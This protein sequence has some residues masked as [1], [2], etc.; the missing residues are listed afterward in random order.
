MR[1]R[2]KNSSK[3]HNAAAYSVLVLLLLVVAVIGYFVWQKQ[4]GRIHTDDDLCPVDTELIP[5]RTAI[6][7]D[8][9]D[10]LTAVQQESLERTLTELI[11][12]LGKY[13]WLGVYVLDEQES[14]FPRPAIGKC[15]PG[16]FDD[17]NPLYENPKNLE[18]A[19]MRNFFVPLQEALTK[20]A[21]TSGE[22][23][24]SPILEMIN[25]VV[26]DGNW[27]AGRS[28]SRLL[29]ISDMLHNTQEYSHYRSV[30]DFDNFS[31]LDYAGQFFE[32]RMP[33]TEVEIL[34]VRRQ[35][36]SAR[37]TRGHIKFWEDYFSTVGARLVRVQ[38]L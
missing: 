24:T 8:A 12:K 15:Y 13:E 19:M 10:P 35:R 33:G 5:A 26:V 7:I 20:V 38:T 3:A 28:T 2:A 18:R 32:S 23:S 14:S 30:P 9:S 34:L 1:R 36:D 27:R 11:Q 17:A 37:H 29:I 4:K 31:E 21:A 16:G 25:G 6:L 22:Q